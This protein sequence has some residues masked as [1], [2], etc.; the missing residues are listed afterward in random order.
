[1][2]AVGEA[3]DDPA[4]AWRTVPVLV[5]TILVFFFHKALHLEPATVALAG[6]SVMLLLARQPLEGAPA[7]IEWP[8]LFFLIGLFVMVARRHDRS[9]ERCPLPCSRSPS[10]VA[11][12]SR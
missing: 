8:T 4:E 6:A 10:L 2:R 12:C 11:G 1:M 9:D 5:A 7:G 3:V